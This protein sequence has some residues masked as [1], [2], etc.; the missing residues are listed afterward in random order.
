MPLALPDITETFLIVGEGGGDASLIR[1][2]C[3]DRAIAGFQIE[4]AGGSSKFQ[5]FV[6]GLSTRR[7][8]DQLRALIIVADCDESPDASFSEIR[9]QLK[10]AKLPTPDNPFTFAQRHD[11]FAVYVLMLPF[12]GVAAT[13]GALETVLLPSAEAHL[14]NHVPCLD[15]WC[16]CLNLSGLSQSHRDKVRLRSLLTA[17]N[18]E[19][20][21]VGL[22]WA[23]SPTRNL[24]PLGHSCFDELANLI[25]SIP[26]ICPVAT[27]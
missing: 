12:Q 14:S 24:I 23:I 6:D 15:H 18:P 13:K 20:P 21:N 25:R 4:D 19:D 3:A 17:A 1:N 8:I 9:K 26:T 10:A 2:L 22:Q 27:R 7:G 5:A 16:A 11:C